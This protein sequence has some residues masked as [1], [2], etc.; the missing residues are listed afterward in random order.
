[1]F[2][3]N[4]NWMV[5]IYPAFRIQNVKR[6]YHIGLSIQ[7]ETNKKRQNYCYEKGTGLTLA[8]GWKDNKFFP[9][10]FSLKLLL[11]RNALNSFLLDGI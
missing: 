10:G 7:Q 9:E 4:T 11:A 6:T 2:S 5:K 8:A 3:L 1:M